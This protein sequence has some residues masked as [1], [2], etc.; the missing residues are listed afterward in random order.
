MS[1]DVNSLHLIPTIDPRL[2]IQKLQKLL[3][4]IESVS[5]NNLF[6]VFPINN[7]TPS[8]FSITANPSNNKVFVDRK[9]YNQ[10]QFI[11]TWTGVSGGAGIPLLQCPGLPTAP[12][13]S[14]FPNAQ[15][16][17][18][19]RAYG[20][21]NSI[22][23]VAISLNGQ[24]VTTNLQ[25]YIRALTRYSNSVECQDQLCGYSPNM[26]DQ[27]VEYKNGNGFARDP[28]RGYGDN[29]Y[30]C[31]RGGFINAI[32]LRNDSTGVAD[33]AQVQL[34]L[35]EPV[36]LSPMNNWCGR[37]EEP[38]F[39]QLATISETITFS[40]RGTNNQN[41]ISTLWSHS[42]LSPST[43]TS[44]NVSTP[45]GGSNFI[46][47]EMEPP[48]D[49][50]IPPTIV[51]PYVEPYYL[52][53]Q[54]TVVT[55]GTTANGMQLDN[56]Q[57][58][59]IPERVYIW[60]NKRDQDYSWTDSDTYFAINKIDITFNTKSGILSTATP[61]ML[62]NMAVRNKTNSNYR[63]F[64]KDVGSVLC[65]RFGEDIP[66]SNLLAAGSRGSYNFTATISATNN[67]SQDIVPSINVLFI[68]TGTF[69]IS[70]GSCY[71]NIGLLTEN[72]VL[73]VKQS[74]EE[75]IPSAPPFDA[76]GTGTMMGGVNWSNVLRKLKKIARFGIEVGKRVVPK[77]APQYLPVVQAAD[78]LA[79]KAGF[80]SAV[81]GRRLSRK[82]MLE[83]MD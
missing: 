5:T 79:R 76:L 18:A 32:V 55:A 54:K 58:T 23:N 38:S 25:Q 74:N 64:V 83:M 26:L 11:L 13:V 2:D 67:S 21:S 36:Y 60:V 52:Q 59:S 82:Q 42:S 45:D 80:G 61:E 48:L 8:G 10:V 72:N 63:Q 39:V 12:G 9:L 7:I 1:L 20:L 51:Y 43:F 71:K 4:G 33:T 3:Y 65:L 62:Y 34:T 31:P 66:L 35:M 75:P 28:L 37:D 70:N 69:T 50:V 27:F 68:Y 56:I 57:L 41:L 49:L 24:G 77:L 47:L 40:G 73:A 17:D 22:S 19:P 6:R 53:T 46:Y 16:Y 44:F 15:Y 81:G 78:I 14:N 30:Q 29:P